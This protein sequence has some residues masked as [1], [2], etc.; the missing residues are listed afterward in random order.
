MASG[1]SAHVARS[2][3]LGLSAYV[4]SARRGAALRGALTM[5]GAIPHEELPILEA[6]IK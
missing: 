6:L 3:L 1:A 2:G 4:M 5:S